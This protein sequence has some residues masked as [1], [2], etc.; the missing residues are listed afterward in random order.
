MQM[1]KQKMSDENDLQLAK[2]RVS[3]F[4][5]PTIAPGYTKK[6]KRKNST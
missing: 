5:P 6:I 4:A 1:A 2:K 3:T